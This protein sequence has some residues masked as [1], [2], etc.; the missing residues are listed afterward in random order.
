MKKIIPILFIFYTNI[1]LIFSQNESASTFSGLYNNVPVDNIL[2]HI[3][4]F[5]H[6][7]YSYCDE[8][9]NLLQN[10]YLR[11][12]FAD[13]DEKTVFNKLTK[14]TPFT[15]TF[16]NNYRVNIS[17]DTAKTYIKS[18]SL[19]GTITDSNGKGL[20]SANILMPAFSIIAE[21]DSL[22]NYAITNLPADKYRVLY[23]NDGYF[24]KAHRVKLNSNTKKDWSFSPNNSLDFFQQGIN[25]EAGYGSLAIRDEYISSE[26][27]SGNIN[28]IK[29]GWSKVHGEK[30]AYQTEFDYVH[31]TNIRNYGVSAEVQELTLSHRFLFSTGREHYLFSRRYYSFIGPSAELW[32]HV[33]NQNIANYKLTIPYSFGGMLSLGFNQKIIYPVNSKIGLSCFYRLNILS[34][35]GKTNYSETNDEDKQSAVILSTPISGLRTDINTSF[36]YHINSYISCHAGYLFRMTNIYKSSWDN[37]ISAMDIFSVKLIYN[38]R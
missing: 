23:K 15:F 13:E 24:T 14:Y 1:F 6:I 32:I 33:R 8:C 20:S 34:L 28:T 17:Y 3:G 29:L 12:K 16:I 25:F 21:T 11:I 31:G 7:S 18:Y 35:T 4:S 36:Y 2:K 30:Y 26:R 9:K 27:Y 10:T 37:M 5:F 19:S 22:G 38:I